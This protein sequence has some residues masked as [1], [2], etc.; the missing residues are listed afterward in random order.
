[1]RERAAV[2]YHEMDTIV[3]RVLLCFSSKFKVFIVHAVT[4]T[5]TSGHKVFY[6][7]GQDHVTCIVVPWCRKLCTKLKYYSVLNGNL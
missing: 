4:R 1:M 6:L 2:K 5:Q 7:V 3:V